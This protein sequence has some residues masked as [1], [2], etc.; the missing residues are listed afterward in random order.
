V[1][2]ATEQLAAAARIRPEPELP[3]LIE[4]LRAG[5]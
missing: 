3:Q 4:R 2:E 5:K 1:P